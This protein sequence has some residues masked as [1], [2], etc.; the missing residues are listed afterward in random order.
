MPTP[1]E[2]L[3][4]AQQHHQSGNL[5]EAE[6]LYTQI[7]NADPNCAAAWHLL[8]LIAAHT[9]RTAVA[10]DHLRHSTALD[11]ANAEGFNNL[12]G[13]LML[14][15]RLEEAEEC[16]HHAI[17]LQPA[18][19]AA[20]S[21]LAKALYDQR[22]LDEAAAS[23]RRAI[24]LN[25]TAFE[26]HNC[27]GNVLADL[28]V[29][30]EALNAYQTAIELKPDYA[31]ANN[32]AGSVL[33]RMAKTAEA[34]AFFHQAIAIKPTFAAA[35]GN[36]ANAFMDRG[37]LDEAIDSY[38]R[39]IALKPD[40]AIAYSNLGNVFKLQARLKEAIGCY[41]RAVELKP[42][43]YRAHSNLVYTL[44]F[45]PDYDPNT[46]F[47]EHRRWNAQ[48]AAPLAK[49]IRAHSN[50][51]SPSRRLHIG[52]VSP[53][54]RNHAQSFFT[55]PLFSSHDRQQVEILCYSDVRR[56][57][58]VSAR[59]QG[60]ADV[61]R[62]ISRLQD[63]EVA[64]LIRR[65]QIDI[66][67]DLTMHMAHGRLLVFARKPAPVQVC[68]LAYPGT[69]GLTTID[70]RLTDPYLD[71]PGL[72]EN[73][74]SEQSLRLADTFWCY[75]PLT[76]TPEVG[77]PPALRNGYITFGCLNNFCKVNDAVLKLWAKA[78]RAIEHSHMLILT[79]VG[80]HRERTAQ[81][82]EEQGIDRGRV[83]FARIRP[84]AEYLELY[85]EIDI[86]LD[87]FPYNGHTTSLDSFW[88]GVP[89]ITLVGSTVVGRAGASQL[90]N[91][92]LTELIANSPDK[93][94]RIAAELSRDVSRLAHLRE[95]LRERMQKSPLMDAGRFAKS[96]ESAYRTMWRKWCTDVG[97]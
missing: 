40:L 33:W 4:L 94:V 6:R 20:H 97:R 59:L 13:V 2:V 54:F 26:L 51:A 36:L 46:I 71:P 37:D 28:G 43:F 49:A 29:L 17:H 14:Q 56:H 55:I 65:D 18:L 92:G 8:G 84:R 89:V 44:S 93:Y 82:L 9:Q 62:D 45:S 88:M 83:H 60:M 48:H 42:N 50:D 12:G 80:S 38:R 34:T 95:T 85:H 73:F 69:S 22:K 74:Y 72:D 68:W 47:Q 76:D 30:D 96:I 81:V 77:E 3:A 10:V 21:N 35:H 31:E 53:Y 64:D 87:T 90:T 61:W 70:Y 75:D 39:A 67:V 23:Y 52:Y 25:P 58:D 41:R 63:A 16:F 19:A 78:L 5:Q 86:A 91:L 11:P 7:V 32:N 27:L 15:G 66:L 24:E 1:S 57:D 79:D